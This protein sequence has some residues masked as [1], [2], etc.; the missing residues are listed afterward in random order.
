MRPHSDSGRAAVVWAEG[1]QLRSTEAWSGT[2]PASSAQERLWFMS[3]YHGGG[4]AYT[5]VAA[6]RLKGPLNVVAL[7]AALNALRRR[8]DI[9]R[10]SFSDTGAGLLQSIA[11]ALDQPLS[12]TDL[13]CLPPEAR[14][15]QALELATVLSELRFDLDCGPLMATDLLRLDNTHHL[16]LTA[17]HHSIF[18]G[19]SCDLMMQ[20]LAEAYEAF[21]LGEVPDFEPLPVQYHDLAVWER[22]QLHG[23]H[24]QRL[25]DFWRQELAGTPPLGLPT[26]FSRPSVR[27]MTGSVTR[28]LLPYRLADALDEFSRSHNMPLFAVL[29]SGL[30]VLLHRYTGQDDLAV[31]FPVDIRTCP[32]FERLIGP[33]TN[34]L[35]LRASLDGNP[36]FAELLNRQQQRLLEVYAHQNMPF[37]RLVDELDQRHDP[38]RSPLFDVSLQLRHVPCSLERG[39]LEW[40][41]VAVETLGAQ[42]D[43][44]LDMTQTGDGLAIGCRYNAGLFTEDTVSRL[45]GHYENLLGDLVQSPHK[46]VSELALL[47]ETECRQ[48]LVEWNETAH[49]YPSEQC[50]HELFMVRA[51]EKPD[52][53]AAAYRTQALTY[54]QLDEI[55]DKLAAHLASLGAGPGRAVGMYTTPGLDIPIAFM[56]VL[57]TGAACLPLDPA[58]P[59]ERVSFMIEDS[60]A[61]LVVASSRLAETLQVRPGVRVV[62]LDPVLWKPPQTAE[63]C[64]A[65]PDDIAYITYTSG[66]TGKPKGVAVRHRGMVSL[67]A[68]GH[69][70]HSPEVL[71]GTLLATST[72]F[73]A[74][75]GSVFMALTGG[76]CLILIDNILDPH[77]SLP[78]PVTLLDAVPSVVSQLVRQGTLP[79]TVHTVVLSGE[80]A[81]G[82]L[83]R[84]LYENHGVKRVFNEYGPTETTLTSTV[85][86][87][88]PDAEEHPPIG[89][90]VW[91]TRVY[92]LD[93][94]RNPVPVGVYGELYIAGVGVAAGYVNAPDLTEQR[95]LPDPFD[96]DGGGRMYRTGDLVRYDAGG[97]LHFLGRADSQVK[98]RGCRIELGEVERVLLEHPAVQRAVVRAVP[99]AAG[100]QALAAHVMLWPR[101][102][103]TRERLREHLKGHLPEVM[104]PTLVTFLDSLPLLPCGKIDI[105][106]L[107]A[108]LAVP[109]VVSAGEKTPEPLEAQLQRLW[110]EA[111]GTEQVGLDDSFFDLGGHSLTAARL[112]ASIREAVGG[113]PPLPLLFRAPTVRQFARAILAGETLAAGDCLVPVQPQGD[114]PP[115]FAAHHETGEAFCY[116]RLSKYLPPDQPLYGLRAEEERLSPCDLTLADLAADYVAAIRQRQPVGPYYLLGYSQAAMLAWELARQLRDQG[117]EIGLLA[118]IDYPADYDDY[119]PPCGLPRLRDPWQLLRDLPFTWA[120]DWRLTWGER[121]AEWVNRLRQLSAACGC[122]TFDPQP[123]IVADPIRRGRL[124]SMLRAYRPEPY[125][126]D[127]VLF[128]ARQQCLF[129]SHD[130]AMGWR[131]L[132]QGRLDT[133]SIPGIHARM[134]HD[135]AVESIAKHLSKRLQEPRFQ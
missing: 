67:M 102:T 76:G 18:D 133:V 129:C 12:L 130:R 96:A 59:M 105:D 62:P 53:L 78:V 73:D 88:P 24:F 110:A 117:Q 111:L 74:G 128:R 92:V 114:R 23:S 106:A 71:S 115:L 116:V 134:M 132:V 25:L 112:L 21:E 79:D 103:L 31:G 100:G 27:S 49:Q 125:D 36:S 113:N 107:P 70:V 52:A 99:D 82:P 40:Q 45:L 13:Q 15:P 86:L 37:A 68:R 64:P 54:G 6:V 83:V 20:E 56:G 72:S 39:G 9:L 127:V 93:E 5:T 104:I 126:G 124:D 90:P 101:A 10:T 66:S 95:F 97:N 8:H 60:E 4:P 29:M 34:S 91:N 32:E 69:D 26:D 63:P 61:A 135:P 3:R 108:P 120:Y 77:L 41:P 17:C 85:A 75:V 11:P 1:S 22:E 47:S 42:V 81:P 2:A 123:D 19:P 55:T 51:R 44:A 131:R 84:R 35:V 121:R 57:K 48:I 33:C 118:L 58:H 98:I 87:I 122:G 43:L 46:R 14:E 80:P 94:Y 119:M 28:H 50:I 109:P 89:R 7:E 30:Q 65:T 16:L 38:A